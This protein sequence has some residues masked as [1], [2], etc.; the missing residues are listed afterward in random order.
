MKHTI[1]SIICYAIMASGLNV[2]AFGV[3]FVHPGISHNLSELEFI[4]TKLKIREQPWQ[5][6][7]HQLRTSSFAELSWKPQP[8]AHVERGAYNR[9]DIGG[10]FFLRDGTA[11]YT[12]AL[13]W[14]FTHEEAHALKAADI[15][16]AWSKTLE[17]IG[18]HDARLLVGM[19]GIHYCNAAELLK[20]TWNKWSNEDQDAF[21]TM[22][23]QVLYPVIE[24]F[25]PTA[26]GNWDASM[27]QTMMAMAIHLDDSSMFQRAVDYFLEGE[28]NGAVNHYFKPS[29][30]CQE[31]GR[32]QAHTQMGLEYLVN[33]SEIAWK[34]S[35]DLYKA[36]DNRLA[37]GFEYTARYNLGQDV[38]FE[39]YESYRGRYKHH[40]ISDKSRGRLRAMYEKA[41]N[42][43]HNR[44]GINMPWCR[45][46]IEKTRPECGSVSSVPWSTLM[47]ADQ[48]PDL[49]KPTAYAQKKPL[50]A[51]SIQG[52][53]FMINGVP[54]YQ[55]RR[56]N[57]YP[58]EGLL[59]NS[60]MVQG[61][62]D[63]LNPETVGRWKYDDTQKWDTDRNTDEFV[64]AMDAWYAH[65]LL[66]FTINLQGGSPLGYGNKGWI[67]SAIDPKG[68]LRPEYMARLE[69]ILDRAN[70]IGMVT[71]L[72]LFYNDQE[73]LLE[74]ETA[75]LR[76]IDN[77]INWL[78]AKHYRN[79]IIEVNNE[80]NLKYRHAILQP[81]RV[82]EV[83]ERIKS[84][85]QDGNRYLA[86]TSYSGRRIPG[87]N[88]VA[89]S[90]FLLIHGNGV[91]DPAMITEMV[92][93]TKAVKGYKPMPIL[94]NEDDHFD[95]DKPVNHLVLAV[96]AYASW[97]YFDYRMKGEGYDNGFQSVP[98]NWEISSPRKKAFFTKLKEITG[99]SNY[100]IEVNQRREQYE[101]GKPYK[102][103]R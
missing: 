98:V 24:E 79:V 39:Y 6:A 30:Q 70:E 1:L 97:G 61:I 47:Y 38:P 7:W 80:C 58:I 64:K 13:I 52:D 32:D 54:T 78:F 84:K 74:D 63:D 76:G 92:R 86:G 16:N 17:T 89:V 49:V 88:V 51:V 44:V 28:G 22:L 75:V 35:V 36:Y 25:Y 77:T 37:K 82:H 60:R 15:L 72:G 27:I 99:G 69:R 66:A 95:F 11:A 4:K 31:S 53:K 85:T 55:G 56:W 2:N 45:K 96:Q 41:Y 8:V 12:H 40:Q 20:H 59:M 87:E 90:D 67:N 43:Y 18:N 48:P 102:T 68:Q 29:G 101:T 91:K 62:F 42:H 5:Q 3:G 34:Q 81:N 46:A 33:A 23:R 71:I 26:N 93:K 57:G 65:G 100:D 19:G 50:T 14:W 73:D 94:F 9:P 103:V 10:T 21:R 83:I